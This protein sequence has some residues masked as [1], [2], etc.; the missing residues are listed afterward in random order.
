MFSK[1][2]LDIHSRY[3]SDKSGIF[4]VVT[5]CSNLINIFSPKIVSYVL[6]LKI[7]ICVKLYDLL[8]TSL[9]QTKGSD[10]LSC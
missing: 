7:S 2:Y 3:K 5:S 9:K 10:F 4:D 6:L 1:K 8:F